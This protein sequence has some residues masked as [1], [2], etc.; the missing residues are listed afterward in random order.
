M[1]T[2]NIPETT[3]KEVAFRYEGN[4]GGDDFFITEEKFL[5]PLSD[6]PRRAG[7]YMIGISTRGT[8]NMDLNLQTYS[9]PAYCFLSICPHHIYSVGHLS[10][11]FLCSFVVFS[12]EFL[13]NTITG[14]RKDTFSFL[15][16]DAVPILKLDET[17]GKTLS[18]LL[19]FISH[20]ASAKRGHTF[21]K[22]MLH[23]SLLL[24]LYEIEASYRKQYAVVA[25]KMT[26]KEELNRQFYTLLFQHFKEQRSVRYYADNLFVSPKHLT[27]TVKEISGRSAGEWIDEAVIL[28]AKVLLKNASYNIADVANAL[29]FPN[30]SAFGRYFKLHS[31][32]S[33]LHY[34]S[35]Q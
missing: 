31:G 14:L 18:D 1:D 20:Q 34:R 15:L 9:E 27:E 19:H 21:E 29:H 32:I 16:P 13:A 12:R 3:L 17:N 24:L 11:D 22:E 28:E 26:R 10:S 6:K 2:Q 25:K 8:A 23:S 35:G 4:L 7:V 30:Q 33:P 5:L